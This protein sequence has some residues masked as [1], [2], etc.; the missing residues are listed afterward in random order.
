MNNPKPMTPDTHDLDRMEEVARI[1]W[2]APFWDNPPCQGECNCV[3][4][5]HRRTWLTKA[6]AVTKLFEARSALS[7]GGG[8]GGSSGAESAASGLTALT[9]QERGASLETCPTCRGRGEYIQ[10][11][12]AWNFREMLR[13]HGSGFGWFRCPCIRA[14]QAVQP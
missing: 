13:D 7:I 8:G 5:Q 3:T 6:R 1:I 9:D 11:W 12:D 14:A 10:T 2:P 4:C